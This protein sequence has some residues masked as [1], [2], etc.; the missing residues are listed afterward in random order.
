MQICLYRKRS[1]S[2]K[3]SC[4]WSRYRMLSLLAMGES[5]LHKTFMLNAQSEDMKEAQYDTTRHP[6]VTS[7]G[8]KSFIDI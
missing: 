1:R 5:Y 4:K 7:A 6:Q 8:E 2:L 3:L